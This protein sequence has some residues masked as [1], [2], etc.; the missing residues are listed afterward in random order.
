MERLTP[1]PGIKLADCQKLPSEIVIGMQV[2]LIGQDKGAFSEDSNGFNPMR[3][4]QG[5]DEP[6]SAY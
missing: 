3:W 5:E 1:D 6:G 2:G 4:L